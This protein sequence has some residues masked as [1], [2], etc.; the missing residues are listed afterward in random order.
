MSRPSGRARATRHPGGRARCILYVGRIAAGKGIEHLVAALR[1]LPDAHLVLVGPDDRHGGSR[2]SARRRRACTSSAPTEGRRSPLPA[3]RRLRACPRRARASGWS[4][5]EAAAAGT[6]VVVTDRCGIAELLRGKA[7]RSS[8]LTR[9]P[10]RRCAVRRVLDGAGAFA[11]R[12]RPE[13][14]E[15]ARRMS[16]AP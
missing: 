11:R 3:R 16:W 5:R 12:S 10:R 7:R 6:P 9:R 8:F 1:E 4:R 13:G 2:T 14:V 15:A